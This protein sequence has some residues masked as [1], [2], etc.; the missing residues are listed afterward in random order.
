MLPGFF[1]PGLDPVIGLVGITR[2]DFPAPSSF[3]QPGLLRCGLQAGVTWQP[4]QNEFTG[5]DKKDPPLHA[6]DYEVPG[7]WDFVPVF[8]REAVTAPRNADSGKS[9]RLT[10]DRLTPRL[11][12]LLQYKSLQGGVISLEAYSRHFQGMWCHR[13]L[14][15]LR[16]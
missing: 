6:E 15:K 3:W 11:P 13:N 10:A 5:N 9:N 8:E 2:C 7:T 14:L 12:M 1:R 16:V 4:H